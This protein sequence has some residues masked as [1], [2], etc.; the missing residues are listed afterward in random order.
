MRLSDQWGSSIW[1]RSLL[2]SVAIAVVASQT[3]VSAVT[4]NLQALAILCFIQSG[5][6]YVAEYTSR[7]KRS[8]L[9][10]RQTDD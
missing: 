8:S 7:R 3:I 9:P 4:M 10:P 5:I 6:L 1:L 2:R